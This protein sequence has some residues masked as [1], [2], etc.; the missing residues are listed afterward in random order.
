MHCRWR[1]SCYMHV[2]SH[3]CSALLSMRSRAGPLLWNTCGADD[4]AGS[5]YSSLP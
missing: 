1:G 2:P 3:T 5:A 4:A